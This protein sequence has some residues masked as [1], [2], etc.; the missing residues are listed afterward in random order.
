MI[1]DLAA[2]Q[3]TEFLIPF[4]FSMAV[5][6]GVLEITNVF[7]NRGVNFVIAITLS[8]FATSSPFFIN[9]L[10]SYFGDV[11]IFFI[12]MFFITFV[13]EVLGVRKSGHM[14]PDA[15]IINGAV[16]FVLLSVGYLYIDMLPPIPFVGEGEN[17]LLMVL[18]V[19]VLAVFWS[20]YKFGSVPTQQK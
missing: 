19:L 5:I 2:Y 9:L 10:W 20:A 8:F 11:A 3:S 16:L 7:K 12:V 1:I 6:F 14:R 13:F 4:L 15:I 18:V 17:L